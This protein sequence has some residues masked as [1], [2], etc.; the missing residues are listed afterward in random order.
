L[1]LLLSP[2]LRQSGELFRDKVKR[3]YNALDRPVAT[4]QES[5]L[6]MELANR[7]RI[8]SLPG[9]EGSIRGYSNVSLLVID[10]AARVSDPLYAAV[11]PMLAVSHG[12]LIALS[13]PFGRRGWMWEA[14][15]GSEP[16]HRV[17]V[18][19]EDCPRITP[20]FLEEERR[21]IGERWYRQEYECEFLTAI[22]AV[23]SGDDIDAA[24]VPGVRTLEFPA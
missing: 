3:L 20:A 9:E 8:I 13:T 15:N 7:S 6:S 1:T 2:T 23:F 21:S 5:A 4:V 10:E 17:L 19:A 24:L 14:W 12:Q 16:W 11:R 22:G 18:K